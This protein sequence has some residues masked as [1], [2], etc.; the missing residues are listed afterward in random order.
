MALPDRKRLM[1]L[2]TEIRT[3]IYEMVFAGAHLRLPIGQPAPYSVPHSGSAILATC[4]EIY[5]D[6]LPIA[7]ANVPVYI[8]RDSGAPCKLLET[9]K[10]H[11]RRVHDYNIHLA[12]RLHLSIYRIRSA[13]FLQSFASLRELRLMLPY[14]SEIETFRSTSAALNFCVSQGWERRDREKKEQMKRF[15]LTNKYTKR[16]MQLLLE[17]EG[18]TFRIVAVTQV[19]LW[20]HPAGLVR[21][22][23]LVC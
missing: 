19:Y 2:P 10:K 18:R 21:A 14:W 20:L 8:H 1:S 17:M 5:E 15:A 4:R 6:A 23:T 13:T 12:R 3:Q 7:A 11:N 22:G 16:F 9:T